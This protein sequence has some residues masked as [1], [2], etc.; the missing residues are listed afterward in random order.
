[1][2]GETGSGQGQ[3]WELSILFAQF[4]CKPK[5]TFKKVAGHKRIPTILPFI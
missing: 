1:M 5:T 3:I 4:F 2:T